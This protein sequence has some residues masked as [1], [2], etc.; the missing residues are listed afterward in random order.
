MSIIP[1]QDRPPL[2][3]LLNGAVKLPWGPEAWA[4]VFR[5]YPEISVEELKQKIC[6]NEIAR[7]LN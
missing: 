6:E 5:H 7:E 3:Q 2:Q 4:L 1:T